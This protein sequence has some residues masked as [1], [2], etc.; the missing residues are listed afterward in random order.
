MSVKKYIIVVWTQFFNDFL[1]SAQNT[2]FFSMY[3]STNIFGNTLLTLMA[4][5]ETKYTENG[6]KN[7][8]LF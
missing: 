2:P 8:K 3:I 6:P 4:I 7:K 5:V 1:K